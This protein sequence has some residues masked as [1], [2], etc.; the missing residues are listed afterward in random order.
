MQSDYIGLVRVSL[1]IGVRG[2]V[3]VTSKNTN[4]NY[5]ER[6]HPRVETT[7]GGRISRSF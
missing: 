6:E 3:Q 7:A 4:R 1:R 5:R 2:R